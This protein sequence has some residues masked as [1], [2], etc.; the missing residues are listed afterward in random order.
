[1]MVATWGDQPV[2]AFLHETR[3]AGEMSRPVVERSRLA[4][5]EV[6]TMVVTSPAMVTV[7]AGVTSP[8]MVTVAGLQ[9]AGVILGAEY[10]SW[11]AAMLD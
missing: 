3:I 9:A 7:A 1:M 6:V 2:K 10:C 8:A 5:H 11:W 4:L